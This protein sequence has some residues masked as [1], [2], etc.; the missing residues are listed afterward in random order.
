MNNNRF[1]LAI[2]IGAS[3][4]RHILGSIIEGKIT[5]KEIY[6]FDNSLIRIDGHDCWDIDS[7]Y[8][9]IVTGIKECG[10]IGTPP[11]TIAID[12]WGVDF[13][14]LDSDC[15]PCSK[16]VSYRDGRTS[17]MDSAVYEI[18]PRNELYERTGIQQTIFNTIYQLMAI[19]RESP[20][21]L[22]NAAHLLMIPEYLNFLLTGRIVHDYTNSS[23]TGLLNA[24]EKDWDFN[25]IER[26]CFPSKIFGKLSMPGTVIGDLKDEIANEVGFNSKV[27]L[28]ASHDT[29]SAYLAVPAMNEQKSVYISSGTWSLLGVENYSPITTT[30]SM[31]AGFTNEGGFN[32][33]FRYL[34]NIMGL[35]MI[36]SIRREL[37]GI[38]YV[39]GN[40]ISSAIK[41]FTISSD[42]KP[43]FSFQ[44]LEQLAKKALPTYTPTVNA[45]NKRFLAPKSMIEEIVSE[46]K[47]NGKEPP[48]NIS[49]LMCAVYNSLALCYKNAISELQEI[50]GKKYTFINIVGGGSKDNLLNTLTQ[51]ATGLTVIAGPTEATAL[52]NLMV[53]FIH[54]GLIKDI[55]TARQLLLSQAALT[56]T[57]PPPKK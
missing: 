34:T 6:R 32:Y 31:K 3:S 55:S 8:R 25:L 38:S 44:D 18:V 51:K 30:Q 2:D 50:T 16:T 24:K 46:I 23:T 39:K 1:F 20:Q 29:A 17:G 10:R 54:A 45:R 47:E 27:I 9:E 36:Q 37:N 7:L 56:T 33:R 57:F 11:E 26:L 52:G 12:T 22:E 53:Q 4:G 28:C 5:L 43:H 41:Q 35:W 40:E 15:K 14:L 21:D 13:V 48:K 42:T 19:K 49:E